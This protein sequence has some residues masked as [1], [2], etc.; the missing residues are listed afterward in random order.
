MS[1]LNYVKGQTVPA[2]DQFSPNFRVRTI[3]QNSRSDK[4]SCC[5]IER[6]GNDPDM[7]AQARLTTAEMRSTERSK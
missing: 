2:T 6:P 4:G 3:W 7:T 5:R 1:N